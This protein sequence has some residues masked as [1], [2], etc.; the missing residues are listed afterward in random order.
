MSAARSLI[1]PVYV[2]VTLAQPH[3]SKDTGIHN[4]RGHERRLRR[5][6]DR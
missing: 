4:R 2:Q 1:V 5:G 3:D 6:D